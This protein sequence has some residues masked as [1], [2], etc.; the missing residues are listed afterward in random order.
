[1]P[2]HGFA[3]GQWLVKTKETIKTHSVL[4]PLIPQIDDIAGQDLGVLESSR[5]ERTSS[6]DFKVLNNS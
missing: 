3:A 6:Y 4:E 2:A 5:V 1:M